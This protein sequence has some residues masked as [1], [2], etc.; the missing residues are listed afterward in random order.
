M[1]FQLKNLLT[2]CIK[3]KS[4]DL[5]IA[6]N[7]PVYIRVDGSLKSL[8]KYGHLS[9]EKAKE[10]CYEILTREKQAKLE[11][12]LE[13]DLSF[14][15][16][17]KNRVRANIFWQ[18]NS[19]AAAF[20][21]IPLEIPS[22]E[23]LGIPPVVMEVAH[24]PRGLVLVTG[25]TGSGKSTT[26][27]AM[28]NKI[29]EER[30]AHIITIED[31]VEYMHECKKCLINQRE[32]GP[33]THD[34]KNALKYILR[35]DPD[36]V[37]VG[38]MRDLETIQS[39]ITVAETG[40]LVLATLHTNDAAQT[41]DRIIDVFPPHQQPQIRTQVSS[42]LQ[43]IF[44]QQL[45]PLKEGGRT[46]ALEIM[47]PTSGIRNLIREGKTHQIYAQMQM[48][49]EESKMQT[50]NES[51]AVLFR[52]GKIDYDEGFFRATNPDEFVS[53]AGPKSKKG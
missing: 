22:V 26:L 20:R 10:L 18:Q 53:L 32:V 6:A 30:E 17:D 19:V 38:E 43:G 11:K 31:P 50:M 4:S 27:A 5:H 9:V 48:G 7:S 21:I 42:I 35:Q 47:I 2:D 33:D 24:K 46:L 8:E 23:E 28:I 40:H 49:R 36:V 45:L 44:S 12:D 14:T 37:L 29:N 13:L 39:A 52:H 1:E 15:F 41:I 25:P 16:E 34:F 3:A 51:L